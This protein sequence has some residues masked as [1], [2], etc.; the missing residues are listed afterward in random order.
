MSAAPR[1][2]LGQHFLV[3]ENILAVIARLAKLGPSDVALEIGPGLG[4]L[5]RV[6]AA[7][8]G[9]RGDRVNDVRGLVRPPA[10][11]DRCEVWAVGLGQD[12]IAGDVRRGFPNTSLTVIEPSPPWAVER[13]A[14]IAHLEPPAAR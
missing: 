8:F 2:E 5:T 11:R 6:L 14:C 7:H 1:K 9:E 10:A 3:D 12:P 4:A 13:L